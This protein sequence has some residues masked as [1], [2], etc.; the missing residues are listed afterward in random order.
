MKAQRRAFSI[1]FLFLFLAIIHLILNAKIISSGYEIV[2][3]KSK[4]HKIRSEN[5]EL[6]LLAAQKEDLSK[7]DAAA[8][9]NG[10]VFP[11][12]VLFVTTEGVSSR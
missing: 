3:L 6:S 2:E 12:K 11:Q 9:K 7:I 5:R 10:M 1:L 4:L 8:K